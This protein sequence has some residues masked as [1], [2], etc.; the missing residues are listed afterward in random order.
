M[1]NKP[2]TTRQNALIV[3]PMMIPSLMLK[4]GFSLSS[5]SMGAVVD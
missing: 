3:Q 2:S 5:D 1:I 4:S